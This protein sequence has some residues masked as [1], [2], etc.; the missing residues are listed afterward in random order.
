MKVLCGGEALPAIW[1]FSVGVRQRS[2]E[3]LRTDRDHD[4][5]FSHRLKKQP[6]GA[7]R[8]TDAN[9]QFYVLDQVCN[10]SRWA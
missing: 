5:V 3:R 8:T 1:R 10:Q 2:V 6:A 7:D 4:L 9:T